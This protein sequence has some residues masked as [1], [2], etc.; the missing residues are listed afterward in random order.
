MREAALGPDHPD[1]LRSRSNLAIAYRTRRPAR[2]SDRAVSRRRSSGGRPSWAPTTPTRS[3]AATTSPSAYAAAGRQAEAIALHEETLKL[4]EA[5]LGP[6]HPDT[7]GSRNNL[8]NAYRAAGRTA[9]AIALHEGTLKLRRR[10][11]APTT[12]HTLIAATT[13][14]SPT[15]IAGRTAEAIALLEETL[16]R[17][18]AKLGPDHPDTL[19]SRNNLAIAYLGRRPAR[20]GDRAA[21]GDA[22]AAGGQA[23]PRPP[24]H[25]QQPQQP[26]HRLRCRRPAGRGDR[27][28]RGDAPGC[29]KPSWAPTTP[30]RSPAAAAWPPPTSRSAG[31]PRPRACIATCW[32]AAARAVRPDSPL[33][34]DRPPRARPVPAGAV[35]VVG[36]RAAAARGRGD[37]R[38]GDPRRLVAVRRDEP[39]GRGAAGPGSPRRGRALGRRRLRGDEGPRAADRRC[40]PG[41]GS[42][43][44]PSGWC[45][46]TRAG[47]ARNRPPSGR[48][49]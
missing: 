6:D 7:L 48:P 49:S 43:R 45:I 15:R 20:R 2:R 14:P 13:W 47:A 33:L 8:A 34:A 28:A 29:R 12:P 25:A 11:W 23:G 24:R 35:A 10:S 17:M 3:P 16:K 39:A 46:C 38:E 40:R 32:P 31:G 42:A 26:G 30:T 22:Q 9:E 1:T 27:A 4:R 37:P 19:V 44:R 21:R 5:K 18:E 36:G 41:R